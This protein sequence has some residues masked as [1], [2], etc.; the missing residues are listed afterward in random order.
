MA[1]QKALREKLAR[2]SADMH[3]ILDVAKADNNR[4]LTSDERTKWHALQ[5]EYNNVEKDIEIAEATEKISNALGA[6]ASPAAAAARPGQP[7]IAEFTVEQM[8]DMFSLKPAQVR[9]REK[10][11]AANPYERAF[12]N[13]LRQGMQ[14]EGA[15]GISS[16]DRNLLTQ[17]TVQNAQSGTVG[18]QGGYL[19][20]QGFSDNLMEA[21][22][23]FGGIDGVVG[24]FPTSTGNQV[25][26]PTINDT[27]NKGRILGQN[28]QAVETDF[29]TGQVMFNAYIGSSDIVLIPIALIED[30]YFDMDALTARLLGIRLG[31]LLNWKGTVG[32]GS[33]EPTG[34]VTAAANA[35]NVVQLA[36]GNTTSISYANL[37]TVE[38]S[39]DPAYR[40]NPATRWMM[41]D[42][43]LKNI[44]LLTDSQGRPLWQ[45]SLTASFREGAQVDITASKPTIL[46]HPYIINQDMATPA[47][48]A[49]SLLFGDMSLFKLRRVAG[50]ITVQRLV[51]R[52]AEYLQ[53]AFQAFMRFD[54]NLVDAGTHPI[55]VMQQS[56]T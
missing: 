32:T 50:G 56:A 54:C 41:S 29:V 1:Y 36:A 30:S 39:V 22:K 34:I 12:H 6:P 55:A 15:S 8:R 4:G 2:L 38:H 35:G 51:E 42:A 53:V 10:L 9:E 21:M 20:P 45:P 47:A 19:I 33:S 27:T 28:V 37:V 26:W 43:E 7:Q 11:Y 14:H 48:S 3:A 18:S 17:I 52:Y 25:P 16:D 23:W 5:E 24:E 40:F 13:Y 46:D 49:Y 31:R 44:K